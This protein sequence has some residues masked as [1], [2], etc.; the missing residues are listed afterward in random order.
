M[1]VKRKPDVSNEKYQELWKKMENSKNKET[2]EHGDV[3]Q[4]EI[5]EKMIC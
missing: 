5:V 3:T 4:P 2:C 1:S